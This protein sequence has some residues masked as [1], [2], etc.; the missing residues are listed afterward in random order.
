MYIFI[1]VCVY[2]CSPIHPQP[3]VTAH[4]PSCLSFMGTL[5]TFYRRTVARIST[6]FSFLF[7]F[8]FTCP[9]ST[10]PIKIVLPFH[11]FPTSCMKMIFFFLLPLGWKTFSTAFDWRLFAFVS[12]QVSA[13]PRRDTWV[14]NISLYFF[15]YITLYIYIYIEFF[16]LFFLSLLHLS[17]LFSISLSLSLSFSLFAFIFKYR[18]MFLSNYCVIHESHRTIFGAE[19]G[20]FFIGNPVVNGISLFRLAGFHLLPGCI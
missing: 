10:S 2:V 15:L 9:P 18:R 16:S 17:Q 8:S 5:L 11:P 4:T 19:Q 6:V 3:P 20:I 13:L 1:Y 14:E 12:L 7:F